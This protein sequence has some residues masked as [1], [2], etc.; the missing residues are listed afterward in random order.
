MIYRNV[1]LRSYARR[2]QNIL[3]ILCLTMS[4]SVFIMKMEVERNG[5]IN[6]IPDTGVSP[7][8]KLYNNKTT[9]HLLPQ[10]EGILPSVNSNRPLIN[11][12]RETIKLKNYKYF[13]KQENA[14]VR[15]PQTESKRLY[16]NHTL[17][18]TVQWHLSKSRAISVSNLDANL[19]STTE[20]TL[21]LKS[22][23]KFSQNTRIHLVLGTPQGPVR[24]KESELMQRNSSFI[25]F[26][27][28]RRK[29]TNID[30]EYF[31]E[32]N[33]KHATTAT[34]ANKYN[35]W[36]QS[37]R[38]I[39]STKFPGNYNSKQHAPLTLKIIPT[40]FN[41]KVIHSASHKHSDIFQLN[42]NS[43]NNL[44]VKSSSKS[45]INEA[46][47]IPVLKDH[48]TFLYK[49]GLFKHHGSKHISK[50]EKNTDEN[51]LFRPHQLPSSTAK[52]NNRTHSTPVRLTKN[53]QRQLESSRVRKQ[54]N[55]E[56]FLS[57]ESNISFSNMKTVD[58]PRNATISSTR[59][60]QLKRNVLENYSNSLVGR[61]AIKSNG[62]TFK[63]NNL[64]AIEHGNFSFRNFIEQVKSS[65]EEELLLLR[66]LQDRYQN[67]SLDVSY[68]KHEADKHDTSLIVN[69]G[70][71]NDSIK[72]ITDNNNLSTC[73]SNMTQIK[74]H[75][76]NKKFQ[77]VQQLR[78]NSF[79]AQGNMLYRHTF[80]HQ[81]ADN[82]NN[83]TKSTEELLRAKIS[84]SYP[85]DPLEVGGGRWVNDVWE[86][87]T[88][89]PSTLPF[90]F[91]TEQR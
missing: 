49:D 48:K 56:E 23:R 78:K 32:L 45:S 83:M 85:Y 74:Q 80:M 15:V 29:I 37:S 36:H 51:L 62:M 40:S 43:S 26:L 68:S 20:P 53:S 81:D 6:S 90:Y 46:Y 79:L 3:L 86:P 87:N 9:D 57:S 10:R 69:K 58:I 72:N 1:R 18:S 30:D 14:N 28:G 33:A 63:E 84:R 38:R 34:D 55:T 66:K 67:V 44:S 25:R 8:L 61:E 17:T 27:Q 21:H 19:I 39:Q 47:F 91:T 59:N 31:P 7:T 4:V 77:N 70:N 89:I 88:I 35:S 22:N 52:E 73:C 60:S 71:M 76:F 13:R 65:L 75:E 5:R 64:L 12:S 11:N 42:E 2:R 82:S 16:S 24:N 54:S 41:T 50:R